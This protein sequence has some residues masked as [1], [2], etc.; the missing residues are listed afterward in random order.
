M[1]TSAY[2]VG[3]APPTSGGGNVTGA[4]ATDGEWRK[5]TASQPY[6]NCVEVAGSDGAVRVRNSRDRSGAVLRF[7]HDEWNAFLTGARGGE[8]DLPG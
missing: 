7:T 3:L 2:S 4:A 8:F 1:N 6:G 5:S